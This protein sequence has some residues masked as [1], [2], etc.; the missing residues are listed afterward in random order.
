MHVRVCMPNECFRAHMEGTEQ[1]WES[2][3][4][5]LLPCGHV[6]PSIGA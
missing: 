4:S 3:V 5:P 6:V 2:A 1:L